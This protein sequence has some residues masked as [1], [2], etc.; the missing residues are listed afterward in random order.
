M[1]AAEVGNYWVRHSPF[2]PNPIF[3]T[4]NINIIIVLG[5]WYTFGPLQTIGWHRVDFFLFIILG[6]LG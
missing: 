5:T 6:G 2:L 1:E 4:N 3:L